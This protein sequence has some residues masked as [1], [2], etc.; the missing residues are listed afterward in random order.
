MKSHKNTEWR[1]LS[2]NLRISGRF[3]ISNLGFSDIF[4]VL[5]LGLSDKC[6]IFALKFRY[7]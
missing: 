6:V 1:L 3:G 7:L 5:N 2:L 4:D